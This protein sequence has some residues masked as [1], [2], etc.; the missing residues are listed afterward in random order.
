MILFLVVWGFGVTI[1]IFCPNKPFSSVDLPALG[2]PTIATT[3]DLIVSF[4]I[5]FKNFPD[6]YLSG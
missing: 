5:S 6:D 2:G 3:P 1:E 4:C